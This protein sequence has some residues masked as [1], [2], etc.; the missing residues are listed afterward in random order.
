MLLS[1]T[2]SQTYTRPVLPVLITLAL[3]PFDELDYDPD[4]WAAPELFRDPEQQLIR[5]IEKNPLLSFEDFLKALKFFFNLCCCLI[6]GDNVSSEPPPVLAKISTTLLPFNFLSTGQGANNDS[7]SSCSDTDDDS[8]KETGSSIDE[9]NTC[10]DSVQVYCTPRKLFYRYSYQTQESPPLPSEQ[11][12]AT[13]QT[14]IKVPII[15]KT[16]PAYYL[17]KTHRQPHI[18]FYCREEANKDD[19]DD[20]VRLFCAGT[21]SPRSD[22]SGNAGIYTIKFYDRNFIVKT[23]NSE[24]VN[25]HDFEKLN[26][27]RKLLKLEKDILKQIEHENI[28]TLMGFF[29]L[30]HPPFG[31]T[32]MIFHNEGNELQWYLNHQFNLAHSHAF[33]ITVQLASALDYL[34]KRALIYGDLKGHNILLSNPDSGKIT[35]IDFGYCATAEKRKQLKLGSYGSIGWFP[36]EYKTTDS[37]ARDLYDYGLILFRVLFNTSHQSRYDDF[38]TATIRSPAKV[39]SLIIHELYAQNPDFYGISQDSLESPDDPEALFLTKM[40]LIKSKDEC[41][42]LLSILT[43]QPKPEERLT[44]RQVVEILLKYQEYHQGASQQ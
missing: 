31:M 1:P 16:E 3:L 35:L 25:K 14:E 28:V 10:T 13:T 27:Y 19:I 6:E 39:C 11:Y 41:L 15:S 20:I 29:F 17:T 4:E 5:Y 22:L 37:T 8:K 2:I 33:V 7:D 38:E 44:I 18:T 40:S 9:S 32:A 24:M 36:P 34:H 26:H 21:L 23:I 43:T 42:H 12:A 30:P